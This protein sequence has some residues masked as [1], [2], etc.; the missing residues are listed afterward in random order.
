MRYLI[1]VIL[2]ATILL[3]SC[4]WQDAEG[5]RWQ[6]QTEREATAEKEQNY[7][8]GAYGACMIQNLRILNAG[9]ADINTPTVFNVADATCV[10]VANE[11]LQVIGPDGWPWPHL[12][13][14]TPAP[15]IDCI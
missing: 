5:V 15:C 1:A 3:A 8:A 13:P 12:I 11:T 6:G 9:G 10:R 7:W 2:I 4:T 14:V